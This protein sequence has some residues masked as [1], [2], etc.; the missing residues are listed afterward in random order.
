MPFDFDL[1][2]VDG[3]QLGRLFALLS[4][5]DVE[6]LH[7]EQKGA[8]LSVRRPLG[9][10]DAVVL[11]PDLLGTEDVPAEEAA[12]IL[13]PA[14]GIFRRSQRPSDP[15][16]VAP[17]AR[18]GLDTVL[19][20]IEVMRVPHSVTSTREGILDGFLV[21]DGQPVEY[22]QPLATLK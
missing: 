2:G 18:I 20:Y 14:V 15:P 8:S 22:G 17:G 1:S 6:E 3:D 21:E 7:L 5:S 19:G 11:R 10:G 4:H 16:L 9:G 13:A 12:V